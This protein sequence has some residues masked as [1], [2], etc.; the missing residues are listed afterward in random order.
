MKYLQN[1]DIFQDVRGSCWKYSESF[2]A[3]GSGYPEEMEFCNFTDALLPIPLYLRYIGRGVMYSQYNQRRLRQEVFLS[4]IVVEEGELYVR[5]GKD[6]LCVEAG[7]CVFLK[8]HL[9]NDFV[10]IP[11]ESPK[12][13]F[14]EIILNGN[15]LDELLLLFGMERV[16]W[17]VCPD[18]DFIK[19]IFER[20]KKRCAEPDA[21]NVLAEL[22]G[23]GMEVLQHFAGNCRQQPVPEEIQSLC[24]EL[25]RRMSEKLNMAELAQKRGVCLPVFNRKFREVTGT[26]PYNYLKQLRLKKAAQLLRSGLNTKE[27]VLQIGYE[28]EKAFRAEFSRYYGVS[29]RNFRASLAR[30]KT[31]AAE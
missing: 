2:C 26:T 31:P 15:G 11:K 4:I 22:A 21:P 23:M 28:S 6:I 8:P 19:N 5:S 24:D 13:V 16:L 20:M 14:Y 30:Q 17:S 1:P 9:Q 10:N 12:T 7:E 18:M 3:Y 29:P 25:E 27:L